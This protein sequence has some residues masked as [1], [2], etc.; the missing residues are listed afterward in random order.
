MRGGAAQHLR[1]KAAY[2]EDL[3]AKVRRL[4]GQGL[5]GDRAAAAG[6]AGRIDSLIDRHLPG[7]SLLMASLSESQNEG[8]LPDPCR[9]DRLS[10]W[11][12]LACQ[13]SAACLEDSVLSQTGTVHGHELGTIS[14]YALRSCH[15]SHGCA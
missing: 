8:A 4:H 10:S 9:G 7:A 5:S 6:G 11:N 3:G 2:F 14:A 1:A 15:P 12:T 13:Q